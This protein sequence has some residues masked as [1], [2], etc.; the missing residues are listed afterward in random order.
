MLQAGYAKTGVIGGPIMQDAQG[1]A[2]D[3]ALA[4]AHVKRRAQ[5]R[6]AFV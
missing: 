4:H 5:F 3:A 6:K 2:W 1:R